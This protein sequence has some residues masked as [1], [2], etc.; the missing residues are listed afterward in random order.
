M[1]IEDVFSS[2]GRIKIL[3]T[4]SEIGELN[5]SEIARRVGLNY[6]TTKKHLEILE[7]F[8]LVRH[9]KYGRIHIFQFNEENHR[10]KIVRKL[11]ELWNEK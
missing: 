6:T 9:K 8:G 2:R 7:K 1:S 10:A 3:K 5:V 11:I 4:L